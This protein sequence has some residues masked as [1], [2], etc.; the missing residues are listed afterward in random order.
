MAAL[1]EMAVYQAQQGELQGEKE[2]VVEE[3]RAASARLERGEVFDDRA[4][5][6]LEMHKRDVQT[7][8]GGRKKS[9]F[10]EES[11][12][13][14]EKKCG[15]QKF[16]AYPTADGL[17]RPYGANPVFQPG[18]PSP[19]LRFYRKGAVRPIVV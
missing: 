10:D 2:T 13:E 19:Q 9:I 6:M 12:D 16:E 8:R 1:S 3:M 7:A 18:A 15:R 11:D 14:E 4:G 17:S 5:K